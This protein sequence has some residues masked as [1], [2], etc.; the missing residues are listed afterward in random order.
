MRLITD[1]VALSFDAAR[2]FLVDWVE[3]ARDS[4]LQNRSDSFED[5][6]KNELG[7]QFL[8]KGAHAAT[9]LSPC[10]RFVVKANFGYDRAYHRFVD[11]AKTRQDNPHYPKIFFAHHDR[12]F[13]VVVMEVLEPLNE[14]NEE[15]AK[16]SNYLQLKA[17]MGMY[18]SNVEGSDDFTRLIYDMYALFDQDGIRE[19]LAGRNIMMRNHNGSPVLV[20]VDPACPGSSWSE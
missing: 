18:P 3:K 11:L 10:E 20:V 14:D 16:Q 15:L 12:M 8:D 17:A 1:M 4:Q 6:L 13:Q 7:F 19:D 2:T 5:D 9:F